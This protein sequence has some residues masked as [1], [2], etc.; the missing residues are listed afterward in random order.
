MSNFTS[1]GKVFKWT[2]P[3]YY[4][5]CQSILSFL[6]HPVRRAKPSFMILN[7]TNATYELS[8]YLKYPINIFD[9]YILRYQRILYQSLKSLTVRVTLNYQ[10]LHHT[11]MIYPNIRS[12]E[13]K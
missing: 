6:A 9:I 13:S 1:R 5:H 2:P 4:K 3:K 10:K 12:F 8:T 11:Y 7:S